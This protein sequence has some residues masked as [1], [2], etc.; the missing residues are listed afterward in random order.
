MLWLISRRRRRV[1]CEI[2]CRRVLVFG[3]W[4]ELHARV[5]VKCVRECVGYH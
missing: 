2:A 1:V 3:D 4:Y 5:N